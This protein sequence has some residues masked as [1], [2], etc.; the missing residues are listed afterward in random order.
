MIRTGPWSRSRRRT[1]T[2]W[3][4]LRRSCKDSRYH[5]MEPL[6]DDRADILMAYLEEQERRASRPH[7][8]HGAIQAQ[9]IMSLFLQS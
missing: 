5:V 1:A 6:N 9:E 2:T 4:R 3:R 7:P 8:P